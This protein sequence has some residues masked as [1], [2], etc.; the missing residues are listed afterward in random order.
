LP[1]VRARLEKFQGMLTREEPVEL[2]QL[3]KDPLISDVTSE[4]AIQIVNGWLQFYEFPDR[5]CP[6]EPLLEENR[7]RVPIW[8]AYLN[9]PGDWVQDV[10][11]DLKTGVLSSPV[12]H[13]ELRRIGKLVAGR[14]SR[15][16]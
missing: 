6:Q 3:L 5:Y 4:R 14:L 12:S 2:A 9:R 13:E 15:A 11:I 16:S 8:I 1:Q 7:W 10:F